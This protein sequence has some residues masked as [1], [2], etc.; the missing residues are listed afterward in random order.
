MILV[1]LAHVKCKLGVSSDHAQAGARWR[2]YLIFCTA[3]RSSAE[4]GA[5]CWKGLR[6]VAA[7]FLAATLAGLPASDWATSGAVPSTMGSKAG[8]DGLVAGAC[9]CLGHCN[10]LVPDREDD[11]GE[12]G[13]GDEH[14][15]N[16]GQDPAILGD[17]QQSY[18]TG[19]PGRC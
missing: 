16:V 3:L 9:L 10:L 17:A 13:P 15:L 6:P 19:R 14:R 7:W 2:L 4:L 12:A 1:Q 8:V 18:R 5:Y 11:N